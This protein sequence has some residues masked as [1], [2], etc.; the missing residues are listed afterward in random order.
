M[1]KGSR[2]SRT[3]RLLK[4]PE[5]HGQIDTYKGLGRELAMRVRSCANGKYTAQWRS[6][7]PGTSRDAVRPN[8]FIDNNTH[9]HLNALA[10]P[11]LAVLRWGVH[12][13]VESS[14]HHHPPSASR[15]T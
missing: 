5:K 7:Q 9:V 3:R 1:S 15:A 4:Q 8:L 12:E 6:S 14:E 13:Q 2:C 10:P 11:D